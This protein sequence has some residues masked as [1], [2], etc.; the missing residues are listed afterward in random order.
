MLN[1]P[2]VEIP[3]PEL[4]SPDVGRF[5]PTGMKLPFAGSR[6]IQEIF[7]SGTVKTASSKV[8]ATCASTRNCARRR[9]ASITRF[10]L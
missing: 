2:P 6:L 3:F 7:S 8:A 4:A 5:A 9:N 10:P 1:F